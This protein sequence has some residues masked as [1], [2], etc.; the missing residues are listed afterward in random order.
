[1]EGFRSIVERNASTPRAHG[2]LAHGDVRCV[3]SA[4]RTMPATP[5][6]SVLQAYG[7]V[8]PG[9]V[10]VHA[11]NAARGLC[12]SLWWHVAGVGAGDGEGEAN[13]CRTASTPQKRCLGLGSLGSPERFQRLPHRND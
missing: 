10:A 2:T 1:V 5:C 4:L 3:E 7:N 11:A 6:C 9:N 13:R 8:T 12:G